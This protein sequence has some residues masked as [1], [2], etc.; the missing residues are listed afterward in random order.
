MQEP[1][2]GESLGIVIERC[3]HRALADWRKNV[4]PKLD[5]DEALA[6]R[7]NGAEINTLVKGDKT[8]ITAVTVSGVGAYDTYTAV[9]KLHMTHP[10][11][12]VIQG[13]SVPDR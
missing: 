12:W 3:Y 13:D 9:F 8:A 7:F 1:F 10:M 4:A 6:L 2:W 11:S 5:V